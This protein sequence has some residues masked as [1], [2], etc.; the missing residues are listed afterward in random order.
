MLL[1]LWT[2]GQKM[3]NLGERR[4]TGSGQRD[5]SVS[6][7][8]VTTDPHSLASDLPTVNISDRAT[9]RV[10]LV[11]LTALRRLP[12]VIVWRTFTNEDTRSV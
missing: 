4:G 6:V 11:V 7:T 8:D 2:S 10:A 12:N 1:T 9:Y 3:S 5:M